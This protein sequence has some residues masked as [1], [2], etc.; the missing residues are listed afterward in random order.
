MS[1]YTQPGEFRPERFLSPKPAP[2]FSAAFGCERRVC[3]GPHIA[4]NALSIVA[5]KYVVTPD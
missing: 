2:A 5:A 3:P 4:Q 1:A